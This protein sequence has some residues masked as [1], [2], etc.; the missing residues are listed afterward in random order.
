MDK[1]KLNIVKRVMKLS[2]VNALKN[3]EPIH[4]ETACAS[5][6]ILTQEEPTQRDID[7]ALLYASQNNLLTKKR[8]KRQN[9]VLPIGRRRKLA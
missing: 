6:R 8:K 1:E 3:N 5:F 9:Y 2:K 4:Y 7:K